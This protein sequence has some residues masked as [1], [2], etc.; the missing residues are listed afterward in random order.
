MSHKIP[1]AEAVELMLA[2]NLRPLE[3]YPGRAK[4]WRCECL[5]CKH[6]VTP[7]LAS[8][9]LGQ[10]GCVYCAGKATISEEEAREILKCASLRPLEPYKGSRIG[11][12]SECVNC[13]RV[14]T[15][16]VDTVKNRGA[17]CRFC[18]AKERGK[19][20]RMSQDEARE[21]ARNANL[22]PLEPYV[23]SQTKW[24]SPWYNL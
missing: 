5:I 9:R 19:K 13:G 6:I 20:S 10:G 14:S 7:R 12:K 8:I 3:S 21:L 1:E 2:K 22:E 4:P 15:P 18:S 11:W 17:K 23:T 16:R 24:M